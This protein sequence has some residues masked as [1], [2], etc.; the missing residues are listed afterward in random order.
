MEQAVSKVVA[1]RPQHVLEIGCGAG[2]LLFRIAPHCT[3]YLGADFS[4]VALRHV[5]QQLADFNIPKWNC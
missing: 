5:R 1:R 3:R 2:L 4:P